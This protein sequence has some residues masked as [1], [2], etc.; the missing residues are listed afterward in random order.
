MDDRDHYGKKRLDLAGPLMTMSFSSLFNRLVRD[1]KKILQ[2]QIDHGKPFDISGAIRSA[3]QIT[4][5]LQ[6]AL[7]TGN[8]AKTREGRVVRTGVAQV[9]NRLTYSS[10]ISH[11]RR[12]N[13]SLGREGKMAKPRQLHNSHWGL[14]CFA[15]TPEGQAVGLVKNFALMCY[16]S[17]GFN[18]STIHRFLI[19]R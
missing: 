3:S 10:A 7:A 1:T 8:W 16:V 9:L 12:I 6:Y 18:S 5:G 15:E 17:I 4:H 2:K 14:I 11:L 19:V 13:T